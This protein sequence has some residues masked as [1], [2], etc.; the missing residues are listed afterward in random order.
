MKKEYFR[1]VKKLLSSKLNSG[2]VIGG[3]NAWAIGII[4]YSA[5]IIDWNR[6]ELRDMDV[7]TRKL[8]T[9]NGALHPR[10]NVGRLY[11]PRK[12][13]G[14]GLIGCEDCVDSE[15]KGLSEYVMKSEEWML[16]WVRSEID[17]I[18]Q[19]GESLEK[20]RARMMEQWERKP[21]HVKFLKDTNA[22]RGTKS[23]DW[24]RGGHLKKETESSGRSMNLREF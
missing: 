4:R 24:L 8:M 15:T 10:G 1:R 22:V 20:I 17:G 3:I 2:N 12:N 14:R 21:L 6:K 23:W 11:L 9:L 16:R 7:R 5:G 18:D 19:L 13:G